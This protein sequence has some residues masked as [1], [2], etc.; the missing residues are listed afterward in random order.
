[1]LKKDK[2]QKKRKWLDY[3]MLLAMA[4]GIGLIAYPFVTDKLNELWG[5]QV[6]SYYQHQA[7]TANQQELEKIEAEM[8]AKNQEL[9][10]EGNNPGVS[11]FNEAV[12]TEV[13]GEE[14]D[15]GTTDFYESHMIGVIYIPEITVNLPIYDQTTDMLLQRG[16]TLLE[17]TSFPVGGES[18]HA[19]LSAHRGLA[20]SKLFTD[21]PQL[22]IGDE[23]Y[24]DI[25]GERL[26]YEVDQIDTIEPTETEL[27]TIKPGEDLVTLMTCTPY[28][29]NT[30]RLLVR[31]HRIPYDSGKDQAI[32]EIKTN[33]QWLMIIVF[34]LVFIAIALLSWLVVKTVKKHRFEKDKP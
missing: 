20:E 27:L 23:F 10:I 12:S 28:M 33:Q 7:N 3:V 13:T 4:I 11:A 17:G 15:H 19:V 34:G 26:A 16:A 30:H 24:I 14:V 6:I 21:L 29:L 5:Q 25:N 18:T 1:M 31:G 22:K 9:L 32:E 8:T 2:P